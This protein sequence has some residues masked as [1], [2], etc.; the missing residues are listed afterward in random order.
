M[1]L[2]VIVMAGGVGERLQPL[3][4]ERAKA[5]VPFGGKFRLIDFTLSNCINSGLRQIYIL[6]QYRSESLHRHVQDGWAISSAGLGDFIYCVPAQQKLGV[7]WYRGTADAVRQNLNLVKMKD[8]DDVLILS[9]D[10]IYKMNYQQLMNYHRMKKA[11]FTIAAIRVKKEEAAGKLG[12]LGTDQDCRLVSFQEK[13]PEPSTLADAPNYCLASMGVYIFKAGALFEALKGNEDDFGKDII[14]AMVGK[15]SD[16][17]V[18]DF[19]KEN[20]IEDVIVEVKDGKREKI[21]VERTRDSGY[22][23]DVGTIDAYYEASMDLVGLE[24]IFNL[25]GGKWPLRTYQR[26]FPPAKVVLGGNT[27]ESL[28]CDGVIVSGGTVWSSILSPGVVVERGASVEQSIIFDDVVIEPGARVRRAIIDKESI[29]RSGASV[30][31][32]H[33]VDRARGCTV[34]AGGITVVPKGLEIGRNELVLL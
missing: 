20:K 22:W 27:P 1:S 19:E 16:I 13:P 30:G 24:P 5:A 3:T 8:V 34:S 7:D 25:Y 18:Y 10:H 21:L 9:G 15:R 2:L 11:S 31:V 12:V 33:D 26:P 17:F 28:V 14:P 4:Q 6:T 32:N 23:K 29:I